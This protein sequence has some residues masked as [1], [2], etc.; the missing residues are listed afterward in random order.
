[1]T[2]TLVSLAI[3]AVLSSCTIATSPTAGTYA[4][5]GGDAD[6]IVFT[7]QGFS[8][9][10]SNNSRSFEQAKKAVTTFFYMQAI[11]KAIGDLR[12]FGE[13]KLAAD[14]SKHSTTT[15]AAV[16]TAKINA[17]TEAA[18]IAAP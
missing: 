11:D 5:L 17:A 6:G 18:K 15:A 9:A 10:H 14:V 13:A 16:E 3:A 1:M 7:P 2:Q 4:S 12:G 8:I